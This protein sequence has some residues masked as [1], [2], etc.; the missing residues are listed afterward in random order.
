MPNLCKDIK[1]AAVAANVPHSGELVLL[2]DFAEMSDFVVPGTC[3]AE[4]YVWGN[5]GDDVIYVY[6]TSVVDAGLV[7]WSDEGVWPW[8]K[9]GLHDTVAGV[10]VSTAIC[11]QVLNFENPTT[12]TI[13]NEAVPHDLTFTGDNEIGHFRTS[14]FTATDC[15]KGD[16]TGYI[17]TEIELC[18][19]GAQAECM[20]YDYCFI[21][22]GDFGTDSTIDV[23]MR[24]N[25]ADCNDNTQQGVYL[26]AIKYYKN[27][28]L[29]GVDA[30]TNPYN[31]E[32]DDC[33]TPASLNCAWE[34]EH[35]LHRLNNTFSDADDLMIV[36]TYSVNYLEAVVG[37]K[38]RFWYEVAGVPCT[39][40]INGMREAADLVPCGGGSMYFPYVT[41][42]GSWDTGIVVTNLSSPL[43]AGDIAAM[44]ATFTLTDYT[45]EA[46]TY[47]KTNFTT[48]IYVN[49]LTG[50]ISEAGWVPA[51]GAAW[52]SVES[53]FN[54][55]GYS[56]LTDGT[57]G[58]GTLPR[59]EH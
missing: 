14:E 7:N 18:E 46:F 43:N 59:V 28:A 50:L 47:T 26:E 52:L 12:L 5:D 9:F 2:D 56:F 40:F 19:E 25:G 23:T 53:N 55:D 27:G 36:V 51:S 39:A 15:V 38:V 20:T 37:T 17:P 29:I 48:G 57:F 4:A 13:S 30:V 1:G 45:G 34:A 32:E 58:A 11:A 54:V 22:E 16:Y 44:E 8:F 3:D 6:I 41:N 33:T 49:T 24:T 35:A 10:D 31:F 42:M 21:V